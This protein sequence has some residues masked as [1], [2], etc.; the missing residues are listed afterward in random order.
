MKNL[1][2][3]IAIA[4]AAVL[5]TGCG[6]EK[7]ASESSETSSAIPEEKSLVTLGDSISYGYGLE[8]VTTERY[9]A[10]LKDRLESRDNIKWND[11][12]YAVFGDGGLL[13]ICKGH[14]ISKVL[15]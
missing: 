2:K 1:R 8:D 4:F 11:Y 3:S 12:N 15:K 13:G 9:S 5:L 10:I 6:A 7:N 14:L